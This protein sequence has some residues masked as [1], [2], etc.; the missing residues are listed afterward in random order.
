MP[1]NLLSLG[2]LSGFPHPWYVGVF[3]FLRM[4]SIFLSEFVKHF[5]P[6]WHVERA[7]R[8]ETSLWN[9]IFLIVNYFIIRY[10]F[11]FRFFNKLPPFLGR[12]DEGLL[13]RPAS[14]GQTPTSHE[15]PLLRSSFVL[16][17]SVFGINTQNQWVFI[18]P[19][20]PYPCY[21]RRHC[22][23]QW[24]VE[25]RSANSFFLK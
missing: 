6:I 11:Y 14:G 1:K 16:P 12:R 13:A 3:L 17:H 2:K 24:V 20:P 8:V 10:L 25:V 18:S 23:V 15:N 5:S 9:N 22:V 21:P 7:K 19:K 4:L